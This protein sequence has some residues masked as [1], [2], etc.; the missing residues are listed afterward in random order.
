MQHIIIKDTD[1][2]K[3]TTSFQRVVQ[4]AVI[5]VQTSGKEEVTSANILVAIFSER[6]SHAVYYLN[7]VNLSRYDVVNYLSHG[8]GSNASDMDDLSAQVGYDEKQQSQ[9]PN[10]DKYCINLNNKAKKGKIDPVIARETEILRICQTLCRRRKNN[11]ILV[12][13]P[14]VGKTAIVEGVALNI[15]NGKVP[16]FIKDAQIIQ[17]DM[18]ALIAGTRYRGDFEERLKDV[19]KEIEKI[20]HAILFIDEIHTIIGSGATSGGAMDAANLLKPALQSGQIKCIGSTTY[21]EF[22]RYFEKDRALVR[23]F[24]KIDVTEP[25]IEDSINIIRGLRPYFDEF[26]QIKFDDDSIVASVE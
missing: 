5:H 1:D 7:K 14:G 16:D 11:P 15:T 3:P 22:T 23:R 19:L 10:I 25:N 26:Y 2:V 12:G 8:S 18:G 17:L 13:D 24:Q 21:R 4:R 9:T 20:P 6:E